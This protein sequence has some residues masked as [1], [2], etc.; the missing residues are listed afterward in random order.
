LG[1]GRLSRSGL[2]PP[3]SDLGA[4]LN[5]PSLMAVLTPH[6]R[7]SN[8]R[9]QDLCQIYRD[10]EAASLRRAEQDRCL[11]VKRLRERLRHDTG[12]PTLYLELARVLGDDPNSLAILRDGLASCKPDVRIY[13]EA[14]Y[15]FSKANRIA[16]ALDLLHR[17]SEIFP[18]A[19]FPEFFSTLIFP[20]LY[21]TPEQITLWRERFWSGLKT[22]SANVR[23]DSAEDRRSA[24]AAISFV[25]NFGLPYQGQNDCDLQRQYGELV[26]RIMAG[27][28]PEWSR[29]VQMPPFSADAKIRVG[30]VSSSF[31]IH[32]VCKTHLAWLTEHDR[33]RFEV[34][35][36]H[37][38]KHV[39][40][41]TDEARRTADHFHHIPRDLEQTC[42]TILA[43][44][45]HILVFLEVGMHSLMTR[46][47]A[48]HLAPI[49][50]VTWGH[51][52]T[53]GLPTMDYFIS[54]ELMEPED[55][56]QHYTERLI[57]L[58][59]IGVCYRKPVIPRPLLN[60]PRSHFG[61]QED[62]I[63]FLCSQ[64]SFKYLPQHDDLFP[65]IAN[66]NRASQFV[67]VAGNDSVARDLRARLSRAFAAE[68]L[69][70]S[71]YCVFL[72]RLTQ[73]DYWN[74]NL[75]SDVFLDTLE[76]SGCITTLD[77]I[78][79]GVPVV[80]LPGAF[81]RGRQ[82][83]AILNQLGVTDTIAH[84]RDQYVDIAVRLGLD[85]EWRMQIAR[86]MKANYKL[87]F[88]DARCVR[89]LEDF[90][91]SAVQER[92]GR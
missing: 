27:N 73:F 21:E 67:F 33:K 12:N 18:P 13:R 11:E 2:E 51:P 87:L 24:L 30:Y 5:H 86:R 38:G 78:A 56:Q 35:A 88:G 77:A 6:S 45:L 1:S 57:R 72:Q 28:Y 47:A 76:Y 31:R 3:E 39:D 52:V 23:L 69:E 41:V 54:S 32:S 83:Y 80:T 63:V 29:P 89:A 79:C 64:S 55:G 59:G 70:E 34:F 44:N 36:Y 7:L 26:R 42:R 49:Q 81:M 40:A 10:Q 8:L 92:A 43:D 60:K 74:L 58:P 37:V 14:V 90:F 62:R 84:D 4:E 19:Q 9:N 17:A 25:T 68:A 16:E 82:S 61:L 22:F 91:R 75:V 71:N 48:L 20:I 15:K 65:R 66:R 50:C 53:S 85:P 46:L